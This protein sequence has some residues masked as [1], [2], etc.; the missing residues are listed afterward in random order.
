VKALQ[1]LAQVL[2][3]NFL[4]YDP[5]APHH[6]D[7]LLVLPRAGF[8]LRFDSFSQR[9]R[10]IAIES[11]S[12]QVA[13]QLGDAF[14][15]P[16][17][18]VA[19]A[20]FGPSPAAPA[21]LP[22][23]SPSAAAAARAT[24][25]LQR[26]YPP[27]TG[28]TP[29]RACLTSLWELLGPGPHAP[30]PP[31][32]ASPAALAAAA[33]APEGE[34]H[35]ALPSTAA[36][37][38]AAADAKLAARARAKAAVAPAVAADDD[39]AAAADAVWL[40]SGAS[41]L[42]FVPQ[43]ET[44]APATVAEA[45][46]AIRAS[47][48]GAVPAASPA[49]SS[50]PTAAAAALTATADTAA[51]AP[52]QCFALFA[53][54][55]IAAVTEARA[56]VVADTATSST[57]SSSGDIHP[58]DYSGGSGSGCGGDVKV[59]VWGTTSAVRTVTSLLVYYT[60]PATAPRT[61]PVLPFAPWLPAV[62]PAGGAAA[63][64]EPAPGAAL[65]PPVALARLSR[66]PLPPP[67]PLP[68]LDWYLQPI[69]AVP[70]VGVWLSKPQKII[71]FGA[72]VQ[73]VTSVL[74]S[75]AS[76]F[77]IPYAAPH[78]TV[79]PPAASAASAAAAGSAP[80]TAATVTTHA[81]PYALNYTHL[82]IDVI[83]HG[84]LHTVTH[85]VLYGAHPAHASFGVHRKANFYVAAPRTYARA[86]P[87][88][89]TTA[90]RHARNAAAVAAGSTQAA[91]PLL[92]VL[93]P[94]PRPCAFPAEAGLAAMTAAVIGVLEAAGAAEPDAPA[95]DDAAGS[96]A[97]PGSS[98]A[99]AAALA[100]TAAAAAAAL[101]IAA[102]LPTRAAALPL[103][104]PAPLDLCNVREVNDEA[105][106]LALL[107]D[108]D[109]GEDD[110]NDEFDG[111]HGG[112]HGDSHDDDHGDNGDS[113]AN[114]VAASL[115]R[116]LWSQL[117]ASLPAFAHAHSP[118]TQLAATLAMPPA[119]PP[120]TLLR[121]RPGRT[122]AVS[123]DN[124]GSA[125]ATTA[126]EEQR[127]LVLPQVPVPTPVLDPLQQMLSC[128]FAEPHG[129]YPL[130]RGTLPDWYLYAWPGLGIAAHVDDSGYIGALV[131]AAVDTLDLQQAA[132]RAVARDA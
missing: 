79:T 34:A 7:I 76:L 92:S 14:L 55:G 50:P 66:L 120:R 44:P 37:S 33:L 130:L 1:T 29:R 111:D 80:L 101:G 93:P 63:R 22:A 5:L 95:A 58:D 88:S 6:G 47:G 129:L 9:L 113:G 61:G 21:T 42:Y 30:L 65:V 73:D 89:F 13:V 83:V 119:H 2:P 82:G 105:S 56:L 49:S 96:S 53:T 84:S 48:A 125:A 26:S 106:Y 126:A 32:S 123:A 52:A 40:P 86:L 97:A 10:A 25:L 87:A 19:S 69:V 127:C 128:L 104:W 41:S 15:T 121:R 103:P 100:A 131:L 94:A 78:L 31:A 24:A 91:A 90:P 36:L 102:V 72:T 62:F 68:A 74:G 75:P 118:V 109:H 107:P 85:I 116:S 59:T 112:D 39:V 71:L 8:T 11:F 81:G 124:S 64:L 51:I 99:S 67:P 70:G 77:T 45:A 18:P 117:P 27:S 60:L 4:S 54:S 17:A 16:A 3:E 108:E 110:D 35:A 98:T 46:A 115:L 20:A 132:V 28:L 57:H 23:Q 114:A 38:A 122:R 12:D 43:A